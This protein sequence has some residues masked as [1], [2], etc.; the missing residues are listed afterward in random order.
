MIEPS[1][2]IH[3][4]S[5]SLHSVVAIVISLKQV[6]VLLT[7]L[8]PIPHTPDPIP[9]LSLFISLGGGDQNV[10]NAP[11]TTTSESA[12]MSGEPAALAPCT[13]GRRT[14]SLL[15]V[16]TNTH[17]P[18]HIHKNMIIFQAQLQWTIVFTSTHAA[19]L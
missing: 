2:T 3:L 16:H 13:K 15:D 1:S 17:T 19:T 12:P 11:P 10:I 5:R 6:A 9:N 14:S 4:V 7:L 8:F 18:T